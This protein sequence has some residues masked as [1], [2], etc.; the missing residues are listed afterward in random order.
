MKSEII[1]D[2]SVLVYTSAI[3]DLAKLV[4]RI[5]E[6]LDNNGTE[7]SKKSII[8]ELDNNSDFYLAEIIEDYYDISDDD[9]WD[10]I[11]TIMDSLKEYL[12]ENMC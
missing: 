11:N 6:E 5:T 2:Y 3:I 1:V 10:I 12:D 8:N 9:Y 7:I 4:N